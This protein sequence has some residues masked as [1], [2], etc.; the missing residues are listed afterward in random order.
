MVPRNSPRRSTSQFVAPILRYVPSKTEPPAIKIST[1][2]RGILIN[3]EGG[4]GGLGEAQVGAGACHELE[5][6]RDMCIDD[7]LEEVWGAVEARC[8]R[9][10]VI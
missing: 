3:G 1:I 2:D 7:A 10:G 6:Q 4:L 9:Q 5:V 8:V